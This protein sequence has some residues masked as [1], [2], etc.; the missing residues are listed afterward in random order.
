MDRPSLLVILEPQAPAQPALTRA[1]VLARYLGAHLELLYPGQT[2]RARSPREAREWETEEW[3]YLAALRGSIV[4]TDIDI[5][6]GICNGP[7]AEALS[8]K[9]RSNRY[10]LV[11]KSPWRRHPERSDPSDGEL[12]CTCPIP[13]LLTQGRPWQPQPQI[14]VAIDASSTRALTG[15]QAVTETAAALQRACAAEL[16]LVCVRPPGIDVSTVRKGEAESLLAAQALAL[17]IPP[18]HVHPLQ[19]RPAE[20]LQGFLTQQTFDLLAV[21]V[22]PG[23]RSVLMGSR[24]EGAL[25]QSLTAT[26]CDLLSVPAADDRRAGMLSHPEGPLWKTRPFWHWLG[27][28]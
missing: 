27:A 24:H 18:E 9:L 14:L 16:H 11:I 13:V 12:M 28:D 1:V 10:A 21:G 19:G 22:P 25:I 5:V 6:S 4:A 2:K 3:D 8:D 26:A 7:L 15:A 23:R 20:A 17:D